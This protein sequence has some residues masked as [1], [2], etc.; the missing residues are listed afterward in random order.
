MALEIEG[1]I[2]KILAEQSGDGKAG[3]WFKQDFVLETFGNFPK[4][5]CFSTW[6]ENTKTLK[7][8]KEGEIVKINFDPQSREFNEKWYT[9]LRAW[10]I[11]RLVASTTQSISHAESTTQ[12]TT[13][14]T[15]TPDDISL[16]PEQD[17][18]PF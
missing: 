14:A 2:K 18:L 8:F 6:N 13:P 10:K 5:I 1:K 11:E 9:D 17:D 15:S 16:P 7:T 4:L 3:K 12:A